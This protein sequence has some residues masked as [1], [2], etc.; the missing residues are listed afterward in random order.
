MRYT[1]AIQRDSRT[2]L[3]HY[4]VEGQHW[5]VRRGPPY[6]I[7]D[8]TMHKGE[9]LRSVSTWLSSDA[10]KDS[11]RPLYAYN[12][13]DPF[14]NMVYKGFYAT[15]IALTRNPMIIAEHEYEVTK[16]LSMPTKAERVQE[17]KDLYNEKKMGKKVRKELDSISEALVKWNIGSEED[18]KKFKEFNSKKIETDE[19]WKLAYRMFCQV[20]NAPPGKYKSVGEYM[21]RMSKKYDAMV[22]DNNQDVYNMAHDPVIIFRAND[23][24]KTVGQAKIL[25][26]QDILDARNE[27]EKTVRAAGRVPKL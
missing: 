27:V 14:D 2:V 15:N 22:D 20:M 12:A 13:N 25:S 7:E 6:P 16:D 17:F 24:L 26:V 21:S 18:Q 5:G 11:G 19:D 1:F 10:Y 9:R 3:K 8:K 4:G 23:A